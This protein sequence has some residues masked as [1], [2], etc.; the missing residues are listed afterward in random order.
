MCDGCIVEIVAQ[1][2]HVEYLI[3]NPPEEEQLALYTDTDDE[4]GAAPG[5]AVD[6][7]AQESDEIQLKTLVRWV[8]VEPNSCC[9]TSS[10]LLTAET[11][12]QAIPLDS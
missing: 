11:V 5:A 6:A 4:D 7:S 10:L 8:H 12:V 3:S 2:G 9:G 1:R